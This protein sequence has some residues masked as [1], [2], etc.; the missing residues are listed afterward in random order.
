[1]SKYAP[2]HHYDKRFGWEP[3]FGYFYSEG[4]QGVSVAEG[5]D[6]IFENNGIFRGLMHNSGEKFVTFE[7]DGI[8]L[9]LWSVTAD[10]TNQ[11]ALVLDS[12]VITDSSFGM[13]AG[14]SQNNGITVLHTKVGQ[15][16]GLRN[17]TSST[18]TVTLN[19]SAGGSMTNVCASM[20][21]L[22]IDN[23]NKPGWFDTR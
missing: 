9:V 23:N 5:E 17:N 15:R 12:T 6:I 16:V 3:T 20:F 7:A 14:S 21:I 11:F 1:M 19:N 18:E 13:P 22:K 10:Q 2:A 4:A 8:Y